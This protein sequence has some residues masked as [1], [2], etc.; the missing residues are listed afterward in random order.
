MTIVDLTTV[1]N[2]E[3]DKINTFFSDDE[4]DLMDYYVDKGNATRE[5]VDK[6]KS[7]YETEIWDLGIKYSFFGDLLIDVFRNN[8]VEINRSW[9]D[10]YIDFYSHIRACGWKYTD[11]FVKEYQQPRGGYISFAKG[12]E[13][14]N[15]SSMDT[16][17]KEYYY[18]LKKLKN[19]SKFRAF[20]DLSED[21]F[22]NLNIF[23]VKVDAEKGKPTQKW[24]LLVA[25]FGGRIFENKEPGWQAP[26]PELWL[27]LFES[28]GFFDDEEIEAFYKKAVIYAKDRKNRRS[29]WLRI[30]KS[31]RAKLEPK[32]YEANYKRAFGRDQIV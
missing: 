8:C 32:I 18:Y 26:C 29:E 27:W 14:C 11:L 25:W 23:G 31:Y 3:I 7:L 1:D 16:K 9:M 13:D 19:V 30:I 21:E 6:L 5:T 15:D 20:S 12:I 2:L 22:R 17:T 24:H 4:D 10:I 28:S